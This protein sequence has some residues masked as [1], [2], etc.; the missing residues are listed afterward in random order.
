MHFFSLCMNITLCKNV[1]QEWRQ[2]PG[3]LLS[4]AIQRGNAASIFGTMHQGTDN[5]FKFFF[6][7][8]SFPYSIIIL[9]ILYLLSPLLK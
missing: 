9:F 5:S 7:I 1:H 2:L 4:L 3:Q 6:I 8:C